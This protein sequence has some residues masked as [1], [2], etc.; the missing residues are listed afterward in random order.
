MSDSAF[1]E[2]ETQVEELPLFQIFILKQKIDNIIAKN[3][4]CIFEFDNLVQHTD[5]AEHADEYIRE[6]RD[7]DRL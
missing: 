1:A 4:N 6:L 7:N 5:R 2:L 3:K